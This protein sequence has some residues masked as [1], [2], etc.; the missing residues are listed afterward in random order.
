MKLVVDSAK[1]REIENDIINEI[2]IS[3]VVLMERAALSVAEQIESDFSAASSEKK[4]A[5]V[6]CGPGNNGGDG[7]AIARLLYYKNWDVTIVFPFAESKCTLL[8]KK[9]REIAVKI[10]IAIKTTIPTENYTVVVDALF[11]IGLSRNIEGDTANIISEINDKRK[12][13][14]LVYAVD[15]PSG[16]S[17]DTG[18]IMGTAVKANVTVTFAYPKV[19]FYLKD[20]V[21]CSGNVLCKDVGIYAPLDQKRFNP[22]VYLT[23]KE[24][25]LLLPKRSPIGHKGTFGK[26]LAIAGS[27]AMPGAALLCAKAALKSGAGMIKVITT[28]EAKKLLLQTLPEA[29]VT[30]YDENMVKV[31]QKEFSWSNTT[32]IGCGLSKS[33]EAKEIL[34]YTIKQCK[35]NLIVDADGLN[36]LANNIT[37][38]DERRKKGFSTILTPHPAEFK[39]LFVNEIENREALPDLEF[40]RNIAKKYGIILV[41]KGARTV[42]TDGERCVINSSGCDAM[43]TAGS[44]DVLSGMIA[45]FAGVISDLFLACVLSVYLHGLAGE[46]AAKQE[47]NYSVT[48]SDIISGIAHIIQLEAP[49]VWE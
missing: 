7:F 28:P 6:A 22:K 4:T 13:G 5:L 41:A 9:Q 11:G 49:C 24:D 29:M 31:L 10:G 33:N 8:C 43:A 15:V 20:G 3:D 46:Y 34:E 36:L 39:R 19:G 48:A 25:L 18:K 17:S 35:N 32:V 16:L 37:L 2:G 38:L 40:Y 27:D 21:I 1:M 30:G 42:I 23:S 44:G 12:A 45:A 47:T 26:V 14:S